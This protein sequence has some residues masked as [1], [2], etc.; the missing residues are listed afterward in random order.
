M[1]T[2]GSGNDDTTAFTAATSRHSTADAESAYGRGLGSGDSSY[3]SHSGDGGVGDLDGD[4]PRA[5]G[6]PGKTVGGDAGVSLKSGY[7]DS[8]RADG[9]PGKAVG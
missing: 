7:G 6:S 4:T 2:I 5:D 3:S 9:S 1:S 8:P